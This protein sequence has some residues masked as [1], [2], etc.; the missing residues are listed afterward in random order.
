MDP[1]STAS[2][3]AA[4]ITANPISGLSTPDSSTLVIKLS[5]PAVDFPN[6]MAMF[7][8]AA[9]PPSSLTYVP[10]TAGNPIWSDGPYEVQTYTPGEKI[11]L[12]PNPYWGATSGTNTSAVSWSSNDAVRN[13]YV[14][15]ISVDET[16]GSA[17]AADEVQQEIEA[18]TL[19]LAWNTVVPN[20]SLQ[21]LAS[22]SNSEFGDFPSPGITNPYLVFNLQASTPL[23]N[24]AVRQALEY[25]IDKVALNKIYGGTDYNQALD[26]V[27]SPGSE[28]YIAGYDPYPTANDEGD[29]AKCKSLLA[30][31]G[32]PSGFTITDAY[33]TDGNHPAVFEEVQKDFA[34]C[35]VTVTGN[36]ISKGYYTS[37][38]ILQSSASD[39]ASAGWDITEPGWVPD[40][41]GPTNARSILPDLFGSGSFPGTNWG[42]FSS[43]T[44]DNLVTE[45]ESAPTLAK[46]TA[47]WQAA[48]KAV[49]AEAPFIPFQ[50]QLTNIMRSS[51][52]HNAI[53]NPF[54]AQYDIT[55]I[56]LS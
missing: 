19:D 35:G 47:D 9:A 29:A 52:V 37:S 10:F 8:A 30:A 25:A 7:F 18:G 31:A 48:N 2:A 36:G 16:L 27:F 17:A 43:S 6:I 42:D 41:Y 23:Q 26:Q 38:G 11:V 55:E 13:R 39:L 51:H 49:M 56:W 5:S 44:V 53:Y 45:A 12:V 40:W 22:H 32:Y 24:V 21:T 34:A 4:Y 15:E 28:G 54:S 3:R 46:A 20:A 50:T 14:A 1:T 33:R